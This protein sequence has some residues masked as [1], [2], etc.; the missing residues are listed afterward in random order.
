MASYISRNIRIIFFFLFST[1]IIQSQEIELD[2]FDREV[3]KVCS[4]CNNSNI[5]LKTNSFKEF[6][7]A[8]EFFLKKEID[9]TYIYVTKL[10]ENKVFNDSNVNYIL[11]I[12]RG[13]VL[14]EKALYDAAE[15]NLLQAIAIGEEISSEYTTNL[16]AILG[17]I[18]TEQNEFTKAVKILEDWKTTYKKENTE[19]SR[20]NVHNLGVSYLHLQE[21][22]KAEVN[23]KESFALNEQSKDTLGLARSCL[24]LANLYYVQYK[25][26]IA[27]SYF[28]KGLGFAKKTTNLPLLSCH[29][30]L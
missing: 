19:N 1:L 16:F 8:H 29:F 5:E 22:E 24:D 25:D 2:D 20:I 10:L 14:T 4:V 26:A 15:E 30:L 28:E 21:F 17:K 3:L 23:L 11:Y 18:Y 7:R 12:L 9:S 6:H 27:L 13:R